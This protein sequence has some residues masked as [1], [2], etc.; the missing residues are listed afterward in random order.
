MATVLVRLI[1]TLPE[2]IAAL[3]RQI[4]EGAGAHPDSVIF[5]S[6]PDAGSL[7]AP[8][9][10]WPLARSETAIDRRPRYRSSVASPLSWYAAGRPRGFTIV[11]LVRN[12]C[13]RHSRNGPAIPSAFVTGLGFTMNSN[14]SAG[15]RPPCRCA[16]SSLQVDSQIRIAFRCWKDGIPYDC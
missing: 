3:D 1:A 2:G 15:R 6:F 12:S 8:R 11:G 13:V 5:R 16:S 4:D 10:L 14:E 7:M 9:L